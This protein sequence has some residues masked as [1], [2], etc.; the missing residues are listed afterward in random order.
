MFVWGTQDIQLGLLHIV[1]ISSPEQSSGSAIVLPPWLALAAALA[2]VLF[3]SFYVM[4]KTLSGELSYPGDGS[5]W[6]P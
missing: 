6:L 1:I 3:K 5:F 2:K 4:G